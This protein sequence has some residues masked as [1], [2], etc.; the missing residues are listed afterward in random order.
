MPLT[1]TNICNSSL[2]KA[3]SS[4]IDHYETDTSENAIKCRLYYPRVR[5]ALL[6]S[7]TWNFASTRLKLSY[8]W[9]T[10]TVYITDNYVWESSLL[11]KCA[12]DHTSG[13]FATDLAAGKWTLITARPS[14]GYEYAY[15]LPIDCLR[16]IG[17]ID[18]DTDEPLDSV[19]YP[20]RSEGGQLLYNKTDCD[21]RYIFREENPEKFDSLFV[22]VLI[23]TLAFE[24]GPAIKQNEKLPEQI[25]KHLYGFL[26][27]QARSMDARE[28]STKILQGQT[29]IKSRL[30]SRLGR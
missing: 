30:V 17:P 24:L 23:Y 14:S 6:R 26:I 28:A 13:T 15:D 22:Q 25:T 19:A 20:W 18:E 12:E 10:A 3:G 7:F 29:L 1:V 9:A 8:A 27:P 11:Y 5:D 4:L 2:Y 21:I 16:V